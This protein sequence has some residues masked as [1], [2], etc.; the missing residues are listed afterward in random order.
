M[1]DAFWMALF[2]AVVSLAD[3]VLTYINQKKIDKVEKH[4]NGH[5]AH[6][7]RAQYPPIP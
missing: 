7:D 2:A 1:S 5:L 3:M 6:G 4:I